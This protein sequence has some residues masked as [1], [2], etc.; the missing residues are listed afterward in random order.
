MECLLEAVFSM[1]SGYIKMTSVLHT[2][3]NLSYIY[4]HITKSFRQQTEVI[5]NH[6]NGRVRW[7][8]QGEA[9]H[10]KYKRLKLDGG[11]AYDCLSD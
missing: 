1:R 11:Q 8:E 10:R 9:G 6:K 3:F 4:H 7:I 5:K 2:A